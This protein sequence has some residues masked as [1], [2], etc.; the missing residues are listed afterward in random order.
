[1]Q[2]TRC[3]HFY[4]ENL[5]DGERMYCHVKKVWNDKNIQCFKCPSFVSKMDFQNANKFTKR[6]RQFRED[7]KSGKIVAHKEGQRGE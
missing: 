4:F 6:N 1:M 2:D 5:Y 7:V 3:K